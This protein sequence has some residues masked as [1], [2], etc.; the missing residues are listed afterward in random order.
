MEQN[1]TFQNIHKWTPDESGTAEQ[2]EED[3]L[4]NKQIQ[5]RKSTWK[6]RKNMSATS[7]QQN[8]SFR[9]VQTSMQKAKL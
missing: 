9:R 6:K 4:S 7:Y 8:F 2:W 5:N 3:G 1:R